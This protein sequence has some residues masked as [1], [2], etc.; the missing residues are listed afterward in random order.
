[1][2]Q[3]SKT[4]TPGEFSTIVPDPVHL[5]SK[6]SREPTIFPN[7]PFRLARLARDAAGDATNSHL[8]RPLPGAARSY[9]LA[10]GPAVWRLDDLPSRRK[11]SPERRTPK[12]QNPYSFRHG[13]SIQPR[14]STCPCA[15]QMPAASMGDRGCGS[16]LRRLDLFRRSA[17]S[18]ALERKRIFGLEQTGSD[19]VSV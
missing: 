15:R 17:I 14:V 10:P 7:T 18:Q 2:L 16:S 1:M 13:I 3:I 8:R 19:V 11:L 9:A 6:I 5:F 4:E 12:N